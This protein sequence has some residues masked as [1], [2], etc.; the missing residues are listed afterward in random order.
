M[1]TL[2][3]IRHAKS[4][5]KFPELSDAE[6]PLNK[7]GKRDAPDM[8]KRLKNKGLF[9]DLMLSSPANRALTTCQMIAKA[10]DYPKEAIETDRRVYHA[11]VSELLRV[12][13]GIDDT[14]NTV[15]LFGHN[16]G[17]TDFANELTHSDIY[18]IPTCGVFACSFDV[19]SWKDVGYGKGKRTH[20]DFPKNK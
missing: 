7:R 15:C 5:W 3:L 6:R 18:N 1:K 19:D 20:Y 2:Y 9:P 17:F 16:P 14:W 11:G 4:S 13:Q 12:V 8:G 10:L